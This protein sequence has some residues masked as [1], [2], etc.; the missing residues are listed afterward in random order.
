LS[1]FSRRLDR[2]AE[3]D[4]RL[5]LARLQAVDHFF[6]QHNAERVP[7]LSSFDY[8]HGFSFALQQL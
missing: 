4:I 2:T 1:S 3:V 8:N 7:E 6:R 5:A